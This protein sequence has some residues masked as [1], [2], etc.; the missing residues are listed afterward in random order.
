MSNRMIG[1]VMLLISLASLDAHAFSSRDVIAPSR[2][3]PGSET[4]AVEEQKTPEEMFTLG[5]M[6]DDG[7]GVQ[8]N[9][10]AALYWYAQAARAGHVEAMNRIGVMRAT[11]HGVTQDYALAFKWYLAAAEHGSSS[12]ALNVATAYFHGLGVPQSYDSAAKW[13]QLLAARGDP[14]AEHKLALLYTEGVGVPQNPEIAVALFRRAA[15]QRIRA[16]NGDRWRP[17]RRR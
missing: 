8:R 15:A 7:A 17:R 2:A 16:G 6:F 4:S 1:V 11:G 3:A 10:P 13:L 5:T 14:R 9:Y 12:A